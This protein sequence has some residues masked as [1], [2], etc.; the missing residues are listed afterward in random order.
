MQY[1]LIP[2]EDELGNMREASSV[3]RE[4][5]LKECQISKGELR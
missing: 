2:V 1:P 4:K 5:I 3:S